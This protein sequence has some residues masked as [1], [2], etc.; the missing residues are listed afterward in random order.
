MSTY[1]RYRQNNSG[2][3]FFGPVVVFIRADSEEEAD[4]RAVESGIIYFN[5]V[6]AGR[7]CEC[8]GDRWYG[9]WGDCYTAEEVA[10]EVEF[11]SEEV[12]VIE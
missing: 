6:R 4:R 10:E 12:E 5:G 9:S 1:Y 2:G 11:S 3:V 7:D 8:C